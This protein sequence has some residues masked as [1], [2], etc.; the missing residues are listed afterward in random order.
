MAVKKIKVDLTSGGRKHIP[1]DGIM[2]ATMDNFSGVTK[3]K[4]EDIHGEQITYTIK[5]ELPEFM[6]RVNNA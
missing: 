2:S 1:L 5:E 4:F 6:E 3:V